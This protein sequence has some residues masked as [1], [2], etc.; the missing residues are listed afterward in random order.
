MATHE[1]PIKYVNAQV[2]LLIKLN[3]PVSACYLS[4]ICSA[5][6]FL[7]RSISGLVMKVQKVV[8]ILQ[9]TNGLAWLII[10]IL[11][12]GCNTVE[13]RIITCI[14]WNNQWT[15]ECGCYLVCFSCPPTYTDQIYTRKLVLH[16]QIY[17]ETH[18]KT[19]FRIRPPLIWL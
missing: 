2:Q 18:A 15:K 19:G 4:E 17:D 16:Q 11:L 12:N 9:N 8:W 13:L 14:H 7:L 5:I 3:I 10:T 1:S 6:N